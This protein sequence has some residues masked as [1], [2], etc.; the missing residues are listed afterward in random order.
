MVAMHRDMSVPPASWARNC[1]AAHGFDRAGTGNV[2]KQARIARCR[3][4]EQE[5]DR[6][7]RLMALLAVRLAAVE[8]E[9]PYV[10]GPIEAAGGDVVLLREPERAVVFG[11]DG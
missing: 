10:G 4:G 9:R 1:F 6:H 11:V 8:L 3:K 2:P 7:R 5:P